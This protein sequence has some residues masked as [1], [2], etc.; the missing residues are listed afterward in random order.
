MKKIFIIVIATLLSA[1]SS[2][3]PGSAN[4]QGGVIIPATGITA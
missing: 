1:C 2:R 4:I 3:E